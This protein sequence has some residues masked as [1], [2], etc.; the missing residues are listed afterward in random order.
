MFLWDEAQWT[1][2][3]CE[4]LLWWYGAKQSAGL[5]FGGYPFVHNPGVGAGGWMVTTG[6]AKVVS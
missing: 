4:G 5:H 1:N 3:Y 6:G 2:V